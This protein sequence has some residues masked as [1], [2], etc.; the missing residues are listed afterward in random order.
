MNHVRTVV[1]DETTRASSSSSSSSS[2]L[3]SS[4]SS[5]ATESRIINGQPADVAVGDVTLTLTL[6]LTQDYAIQFDQQLPDS[7][8]HYRGRRTVPRPRRRPGHRGAGQDQGCRHVRGLERDGIR[9]GGFRPGPAPPGG[10]LGRRRGGQAGGAGDHPSREIDWRCPRSHPPVR[11]RELTMEIKQGKSDNNTKQRS[12]RKVKSCGLVLYHIE[13]SSVILRVLSV[14]VVR[15]VAGLSPLK[16]R[17]PEASAP[18]ASDRQSRPSWAPR[19][20]ATGRPC[21]SA[22]SSAS[23]P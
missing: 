16:T 13:P 23:V 22:T 15:V 12:L 18:P 20:E 19:A 6:T 17:P 4:S 3:L 11:H 5:Q 21:S 9:S 14:V 10:R 2:R 8:R 1:V 7:R